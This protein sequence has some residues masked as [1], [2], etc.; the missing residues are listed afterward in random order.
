MIKEK[1]NHMPFFDMK[2]AYNLFDKL[3]Y[4]YKTL[5]KNETTY[6]Y[7]NF[8][9]TSRHLEYWILNDDSFDIIIKKKCSE[10]LD[11]KTNP[12]W[13]TI[14]SLCN[15]EKHFVLDKRNL[16]YEKKKIKYNRLFD[17]NKIDFSNFSYRTSCYMVEVGKEMVDLNL[18]CY[19]IM[20]D[21]EKIFNID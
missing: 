10:I 15:R 19:K 21:Y 3:I 9:F 8:I 5:S 12:E 7:M 6:N 18:V 14:V 1:Q 16:K 11:F 4:D 2:N 13:S 17:Y 20:K